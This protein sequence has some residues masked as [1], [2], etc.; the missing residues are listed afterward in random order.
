MTEAR[1]QTS[2][3]LTRL[4]DDIVYGR[5]EPGLKL[6]IEALQER[7]QTG[8]TPLREALNMLVPTGIIERLEQ[9]G[10]RVAQVSMDEFDE[11][12]WTRCFLEDRALRESI[13]HGDE[14]WEEGV[15]LALH[16]LRKHT[17]SS[18]TSVEAE[19][20]AWEEVH[21]RFHTQ[22]IS[23]CK[24][25]PL[26]RFCQQLHDENKRYRYIARLTPRGRAGALKEHEHIA[27]AV[28]ARDADEAA[29]LLNEHYNR[30]GSL[31]REKLAEFSQSA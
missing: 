18:E 21:G 14:V 26:L 13:A 23:G 7:Y 5:L 28:L 2:A 6:K 25:R 20:E 17:L 24:S 15:V 9:R 10:F 16:H 12:L 3:L 31:L 22:L 19:E 11:L 27:Q 1:S 8:A 30:T 4:R 29:R